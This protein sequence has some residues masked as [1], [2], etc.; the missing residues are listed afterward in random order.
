MLLPYIK[1]TPKVGQ[2]LFIL[3]T[4]DD[5]Y[6]TKNNQLDISNITNQHP[7]ISDHDD[8][9][10]YTALYCSTSCQLWSQS[11]EWKQH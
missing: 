9:F 6:I 7:I 11:G 5:F 1:D 3:T 4:D 10:L 8:H 2:G